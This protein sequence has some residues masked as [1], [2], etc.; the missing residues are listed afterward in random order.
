MLDGALL[1]PGRFDRRIDVPLPNLEGREAIL[2]AYLKKTKSDETVRPLDI[3]RMTVF[4][5]GADL[6][7]IVNEAGLIAIRDNRFAISQEDLILATQRVSMG[8]AYSRKILTSEL[9]ATAYHEAGHA[10]VCYY[11]NR[12]D[13][14]QILTIV[15][16]GPALGYLWSVE[17]EDYVQQNMHEYLVDIEVSLGGY[18][19]ENLHM[20]TTT[21]GVSS[22]LKHVATIARA[23]VRDCETRGNRK[24]AGSPETERELEVETKQI[25][26]GCLK[27]VQD[28]L[29][30]RRAQLDQLAQK[31]LE[32]ET[33][34]YEDIASILEPERSK[35]EIKKE[36]E[37]L[38]E[39]RLVGKPPIIDFEN[40]G[41]LS[42]WSGNG[43]TPSASG[44]GGS[45]GAAGGNAGQSNSDAL[46]G[47][48]SDKDQANPGPAG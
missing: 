48:P 47:A 33:L 10:M 23:M 11:R 45:G 32:K 27:N 43:G 30:S 8:M 16:R 42:G 7:N 46:P 24:Y 38:A 29:R 14:I 3:A 35:E 12:R 44:T 2:E 19:A 9:Q 26:E 41:S 22:D 13:R 34:F 4:K 21:S 1:R 28:L 15:P 6:Q 39:R 20:E 17:K 18:A 40:F 37:L 5:A 36:I 31:L 25:V